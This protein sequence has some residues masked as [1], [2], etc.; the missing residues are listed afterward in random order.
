[1]YYYVLRV[2]ISSNIFY[3]FLLSDFNAMYFSIL[4]RQPQS[5]KNTLEVFEILKCKLL[6]FELI[7]TIKPS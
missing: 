2:W 3:V 5:F 7:N 4:G 6:F 1:M